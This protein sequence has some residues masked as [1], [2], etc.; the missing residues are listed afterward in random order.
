MTQDQSA[1]TP[2]EM[3]QGDTRTIMPTVHKLLD[4][5][6]EIDRLKAELKVLNERYAEREAEVFTLMDRENVQALTVVTPGGNKSVYRRV[7]TYYSPVAKNK[8][9]AL[10]WLRENGYDHLFKE[11]IHGGTLTAEMKQRKEEGG[12]IPE[13]FINEA[14]INR[15]VIKKA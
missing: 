10:S 4:Q 9:E 3:F 7:D 1:T 6:T 15:V 11:S 5:R 14:N 13:A 8:L 12:E 2:V